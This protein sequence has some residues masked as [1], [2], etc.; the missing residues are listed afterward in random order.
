MIDDSDLVDGEARCPR[1]GAKVLETN[2]A[3]PNCGQVV[4][5]MK[6]PNEDEAPP[7]GDEK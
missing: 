5:W 1:C 3:C 6:K 7:S 2:Y 4:R